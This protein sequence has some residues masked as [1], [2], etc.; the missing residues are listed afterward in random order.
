MPAAVRA[1]RSLAQI[2]SHRKWLEID[3]LSLP[4]VAKLD[5]AN[6]A[7]VWVE[8]GRL[9]IKTNERCGLQLGAGLLH[10][11]G[12]SDELKINFHN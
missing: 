10:A 4:A 6:V 2:A 11:F 5:E 3:H 12:I 1:L 7:A 9:C 8:L